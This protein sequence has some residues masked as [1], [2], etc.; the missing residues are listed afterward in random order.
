[1]KP[2]SEK[3]GPPAEAYPRSEQWGEL[4]LTFCDK[5]A[6]FAKLREISG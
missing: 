1:M 4:A 6:A 5:D 3:P 2:P